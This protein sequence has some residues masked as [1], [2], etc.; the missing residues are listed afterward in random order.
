M[1][2]AMQQER[3][4]I[5]SSKQLYVTSLSHETR[6]DWETVLPT[7][8][9]ALRTV[10]NRSIQLSPFRILFGREACSA[11]SLIYNN[12]NEREDPRDF[13]GTPQEWPG[14]D[15]LIS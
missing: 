14:S 6:D 5:D 13:R 2:L 7:A 8:L 11:I 1:K 4:K 15:T 12:P 9:Y 3:E 10:V